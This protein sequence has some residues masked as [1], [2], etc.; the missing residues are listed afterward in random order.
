MLWSSLVHLKGSEIMRELVVAVV[1][2]LGVLAGVLMLPYPVDTSSVTRTVAVTPL[3]APALTQPAP[4]VVTQPAPLAVTQ[5]APAT[6]THP[7]AKGAAT[8][9]AQTPAHP[10]VQM[11][12][13]Q[14]ASADDTNAGRQSFRK[15][16][17]C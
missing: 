13:A 2:S 9:K 11:A 14:T 17:A 1:L 4:P 8:E 10:H 16:Q 3:A 6:V 7:E 12:Q 15:C 5:P